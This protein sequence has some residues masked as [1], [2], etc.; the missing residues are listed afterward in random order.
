MKLAKSVFVVYAE[1]NNKAAGFVRYGS[2]GGVRAVEQLRLI[3]SEMRMATVC[4]QVLIGPQADRTFF[5]DRD[6]W[7]PGEA[8]IR[9]TEIILL[10]LIRWLRRSNCMSA[11][12]RF[13]CRGKQRIDTVIFPACEG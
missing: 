4:D 13:A 9:Q 3:L 8:I 7:E 12:A 6:S 10:E 5:V 1:W 11:K 2:A